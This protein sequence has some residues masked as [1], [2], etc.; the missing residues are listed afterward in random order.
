MSRNRTFRGGITRFWWVPLLTG[1]VGIGMGIWCI[2]SPITSLPVFAYVFSACLVA[3][4]ILNL[5]YAFTASGFDSN[6]GWAL[7]LGIMEGI[8]G[9]WRLTLPAAV[10]TTAFIIVV[11]CWILVS[12]IMSI[13]EASVLS[14]FSPGYV[15]W[16]VLML[17]ATIVFAIIFL[18]N[19]IAGG[20]AVWLYLGISLIL[21]GCYRIA[22]SMQ[23]KSLN[24]LARNL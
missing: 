5:A 24:N 6:W 8:A 14:T 15:V 9:V 21:F 12:A 20:V 17:I 2:C 23:V 18:S 1:L 16:M 11:G 22:L 4:G 10:L 3:A 7:A 13:A 19:P